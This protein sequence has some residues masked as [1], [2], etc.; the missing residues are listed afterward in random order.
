MTAAE[1][2]KTLSDRQSPEPGSVD[3]LRIVFVCEIAAQ[4][5]EMNEKAVPAPV[6]KL[7]EQLIVGPLFGHN[8]DCT[9]SPG[10]ITGPNF[11]G[12]CGGYIGK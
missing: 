5:A 8:K 7:A 4:L 6:R 2:R 12:F 9:F 11:C 1:I 3:Y 10:E